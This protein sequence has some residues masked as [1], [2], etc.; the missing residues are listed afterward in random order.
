M[1]PVGPVLADDRPRPVGVRA[2]LPGVRAGD[3]L[4]RA[5]RRLVPPAEPVRSYA[6][7]TWRQGQPDARVPA[8]RRD[9]T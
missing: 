8:L 9:A 6:G 4:L 1:V 5:D 2:A 3:V 7:A